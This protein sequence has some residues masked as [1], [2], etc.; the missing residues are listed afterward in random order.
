VLEISAAVM[1]TIDDIK[2]EIDRLPLGMV[3]ERFVGGIAIFYNVSYIVRLALE[4][5]KK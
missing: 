4:A 5:Q 1:K 2:L 3:K